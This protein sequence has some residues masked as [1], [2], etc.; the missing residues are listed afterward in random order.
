MIRT[1]TKYSSLPLL[2]LLAFTFTSCLDST[3]S[4]EPRDNLLE[5]AKEVTQGP[6]GDKVLTNFVELLEDTDLDTTVANE[7]PFTAIIPVDSAFTDSVEAKLSSLSGSELYEIARYHLIDEL[8]NLNRLKAE[9]NIE[10]L[11]GDDLLFSIVSGT[12]GNRVY[13]NGGRL[14]GRV[15]AGNG[16]IYVVDKFLFQDRYLDVG[17]LIAKRPQLRTLNKAIEDANLGGALADPNKEFT[18]FAP[19]DKAIGEAELSGDE[20]QYHVIPEKLYNR[21][22][23]SGTYT[24]LN[25][26]ELTIEING[27][28]VTINGDATIKTSDIEGTNGVVHTIDAVLEET[29]E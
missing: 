27:G 7:G 17:G 28:T 23:S 18:V 11:Q 14:I 10:S 15:D 9:E 1:L 3:N 22:L 4:T 25:G 20:I 12:Q 29:A 24:T 21:D 16:I 13:V 26:Q 8:V 2:L 5:T 6:D 19:T